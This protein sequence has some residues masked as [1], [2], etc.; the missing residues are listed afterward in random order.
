MK[1]IKLRPQGMF[2]VNSYLVVSEK[3]NAVL[4]DAPE[5][6]ESILAE[7]EK[8]GVKLIHKHCLNSAGTLY[9]YDR[10]STLAR[11]GIVLYGLKPDNS[12][13]VPVKLEPVMKLKSFITQI[14]TISA[15]TSVSYGRTYI[16]DSDRV[17]ATV[18][19]GY[20]DGY[21]HSRLG[22]PRHRCNADHPF[23]CGSYFRRPQ[24]HPP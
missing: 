19:C 3:N 14:K 2:A 17:V 9:H 21:P 11:M 5:G 7:I 18:P 15:G 22:L 1:I 6:A 13:D 16:A 23:P 10:R 4:I 8:L 20:A 24:G 12:L